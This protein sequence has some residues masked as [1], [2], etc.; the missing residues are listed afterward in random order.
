[1]L[2]LAIAAVGVIILLALLKKPVSVRAFTLIV[3]VAGLGALIMYEP[4]IVA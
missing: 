2:V 3:L 1:L 4:R